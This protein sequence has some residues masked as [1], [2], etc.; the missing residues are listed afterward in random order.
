LVA[1]CM[2]CCS[3]Q[4]VVWWAGDPLV[5]YIFSEVPPYVKFKMCP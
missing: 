2:G 5:W 1:W 3:D 4:M